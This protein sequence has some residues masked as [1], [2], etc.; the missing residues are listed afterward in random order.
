MPAHVRRMSL[1]TENDEFVVRSPPTRLNRR[2]M[3][4]RDRPHRHQG[5]LIPQQL[6]WKCRMLRQENVD[7]AYIYTAHALTAKTLRGRSFFI[8]LSFTGKNAGKNAANTIRGRNLF[9]E[10][11]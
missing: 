3:L 1:R 2:L 11:R 6:A 8:Y 9:K 10:I 4:R 5:L 7:F